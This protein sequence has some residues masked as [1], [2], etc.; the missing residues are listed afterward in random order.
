VSR[1]VNLKT[2]LLSTGLQ[3]KLIL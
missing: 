3:T 2:T 1:Y